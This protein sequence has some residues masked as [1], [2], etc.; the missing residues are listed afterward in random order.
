V[1]INGRS[2][3]DENPDNEEEIEEHKLEKEESEVQQD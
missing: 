3:V 1:N 2:Y